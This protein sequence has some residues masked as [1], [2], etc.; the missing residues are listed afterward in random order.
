MDETLISTDF[1]KLVAGPGFVPDKVS[2]LQLAAGTKGGWGG[3]VTSHSAYQVFFTD[4]DGSKLD[5][6]KGTYLEN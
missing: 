3:P 6:S 1:S 4:K 2:Y 5:G